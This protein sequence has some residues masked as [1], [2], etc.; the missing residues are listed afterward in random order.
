MVWGRYIR[1]TD[2]SCVGCPTGS[3]SRMWNSTHCEKCSDGFTTDYYK[4][5]CVCALPNVINHLG[6]CV[7]VNDPL[8]YER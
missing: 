2:G 4:L 1:Q 6:I 8:V 5:E 3:V 7:K